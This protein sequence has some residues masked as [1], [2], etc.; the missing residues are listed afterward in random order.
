[1]TDIISR[2][3]IKAGMIQMGERI[4]WGSDSDLMYEAADMIEQ[5]MARQQAVPSR[6]TDALRQYRHNNSDGFVFGYDK[7]MADHYVA[8]LLAAAPQ[9][10]QVVEPV[11]AYLESDSVEGWHKDYGHGVF[12]TTNCAQQ[13]YSAPPAPD[14]SGLVAISRKILAKLY[15]ETESVTALDAARLEDAL[16]SHQ[17]REG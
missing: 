2:L 11:T 13:L 8:G 4:A 12:F 6:L 1:M 15:S 16:Q 5:L 9:E 10:E 17:N 14:V 3:R 7:E